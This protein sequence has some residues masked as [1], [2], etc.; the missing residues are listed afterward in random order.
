LRGKGMRADQQHKRGNRRDE[1]SPRVAHM[2][3]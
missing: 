2:M 3:S 1:D